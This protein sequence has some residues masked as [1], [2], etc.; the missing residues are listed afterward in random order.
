MF[1]VLVSWDSFR[2]T[3]NTKLDSRK[4]A[5]IANMDLRGPIIQLKSWSSGLK[6]PEFAVHE[7]LDSHKIEFMV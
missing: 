1:E 4:E 3:E 2:V 6:Y 5:D 7:I